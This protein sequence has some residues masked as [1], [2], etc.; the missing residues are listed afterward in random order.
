MGKR[1]RAKFE[2]IEVADG[3]V[4]MEPR[5]DETIPEDQRFYLA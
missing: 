1:I 2:V 4:I 3:T 5:Y